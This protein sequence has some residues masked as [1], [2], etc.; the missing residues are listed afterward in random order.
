[1][2]TLSLVTK[3]FGG[4]TAVDGVSLTIEEGEYFALLGPN[5]AG[6]TTV[7]RMLLGFSVPTSGS[8]SINGVSVG[9]TGVRRG[10]GY[11]AEHH[12]IPPYLSGREYLNRNASLVGICGREGQKEV[13]RVLDVV[14]MTNRESKKSST[15]SKGMMQRIGLAAAIIGKPK[16]LILDEPVSGLD[17]LGIRDVRKVLEILK[18]DGVTMIL[19]SHLLSEVEKVC[20]SATI[21]HK[22][23]ILIKDAIDSIVGENETLEQVFIKHIEKQ[24]G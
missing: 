10:I 14:G 4:L 20:D 13:D 7:V 6:K 1:M 2:I 21:M 16:L 19:N 24:N 17:P 5:G 18:D 22:G 11:L 9:D 3:K 15:F 23:K 8:I 12:R